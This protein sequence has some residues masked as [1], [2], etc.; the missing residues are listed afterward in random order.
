[1]IL[2]YKYKYF[3]K[4][5][6]KFP[7]FDWIYSSDIEFLRLWRNQQRKILRQSSIISKNEQKKYFKWLYKN[8]C[9]KKKPNILILVIR[10]NKNLIG[11]G[12]LSNISWE[13]KRGEI[14]FLV[15]P[16]IAKKDS[17]Y[18]YYHKFFFHNISIMAFKFLKLKKIYTDTFSY[19]NKHIELLEENGFKKEGILKNHYIKKNR[20][21]SSIIHAKIN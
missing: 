7:I 1:M 15:D 12:G 14:S 21:I 8:C 11:Y 3:T 16:K 18:K 17:L 20:Q 2:C 19:R 5:T 9:L 6:S 10:K 4:I 13:D